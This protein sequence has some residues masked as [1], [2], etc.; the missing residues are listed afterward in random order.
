MR[1]SDITLGSWVRMKPP[2]GREVETSR[3]GRVVAICTVEDFDG[4]H[5]TI[6]VRWLG[7][8]GE[9]D[10]DVVIMHPDELELI[11]PD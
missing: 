8:D 7:D 11:D 6:D 3:R 1:R 4:R 2:P 5:R 9:P 10:C